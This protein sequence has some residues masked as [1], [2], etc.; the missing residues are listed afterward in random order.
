MPLP[1]SYVA[2]PFFELEGIADALTAALPTGTITRTITVRNRDYDGFPG[3][4]AFPFV[5]ARLYE[6]NLFYI[7]SNDKA[8]SLT[9]PSLYTLEIQDVIDPRSGLFERVAA[10]QSDI[11]LIIRAIVAYFN[12]KP[13]QCLKDVNGVARAKNAGLMS[14]WKVA[15]PFQDES[16]ESRLVA[17]ALLGVQGLPHPQTDT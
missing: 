5:L 4:D 14:R 15:A 13:H 2:D 6:F 11:Y 7:A 10:S 17:A 9:R 16:G 3:A 8:N 1:T 12:V